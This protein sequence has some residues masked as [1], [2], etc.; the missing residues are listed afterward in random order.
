MCPVKRK[1]KILCE[2]CEEKHET[3]PLSPEKIHVFLL[4]NH[5]RI[6]TKSLSL[7]GLQ[8]RAHPEREKEETPPIKPSRT[9]HQEIKIVIEKKN[10]KISQRKVFL[11]LRI[12]LK[13][14]NF[15][16]KF[17]PKKSVSA[18]DFRTNIYRVTG[19]LNC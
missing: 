15:R 9:Y 7:H 11:S 6:Q 3:F 14:W 10:A 2:F 19:K 4:V 5:N 16:K 1:T 8:T 18:L 12:L 13:V 17:P